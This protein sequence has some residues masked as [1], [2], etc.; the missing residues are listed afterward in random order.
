LIFSVERT[1]HN[2]RF[3]A[4]T[5]YQRRT[6]ELSPTRTS[7]VHPFIRVHPC[8]SVAKI[9]PLSAKNRGTG[10]SITSSICHIT[11]GLAA[12][13]RQNMDASRY[14]AGEM[15]TK[16]PVFECR[17]LGEEDEKHRFCTQEPN[18]SMKPKNIHRKTGLKNTWKSLNLG[19]KSLRLAHKTPRA[20]PLSALYNPFVMC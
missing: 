4:R 20:H 13:T 17:E 16:V 3:N 9:K 8:L 14:A 7:G 6:L 10:P 5:Q 19:Y 15:K 2:A 11:R 12:H 18:N 1:V